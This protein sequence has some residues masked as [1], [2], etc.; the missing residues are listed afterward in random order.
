MKVETGVDC[1]LHKVKL[2]TVF[3]NSNSWS[4]ANFSLIEGQEEVGK[5]TRILAGD[6]IFNQNKIK[7]DGTKHCYHLTFKNIILQLTNFI[8]LCLCNLQAHFQETYK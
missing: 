6:K 5:S 3:A 8:K 1:D 7:T 4:K 2:I